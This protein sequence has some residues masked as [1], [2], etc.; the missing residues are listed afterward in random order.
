LWVIE[1]IKIL[2][3]VREETLIFVGIFSENISNYYNCLLNN[4]GNLGFEGLPEALDTLVRH[5]LKLNCTFSHRIDSF[6]Y[7]FNI[8][9]MYILLEFVQ[10]H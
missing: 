8:N 2:A 4:I 6:S 1:I 9:L 5:F 7:K 10:N 3:N